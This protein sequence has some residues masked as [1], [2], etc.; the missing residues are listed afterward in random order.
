[1]TARKKPPQPYAGFEQGPIR[2]P[3]ESGSLLI[4]VTR[5]C[6]WNHCAFCPVY[7]GTRFS[8]RPAEHVRRDIDTVH[9]HV[10]SIREAAASDGRLDRDRVRRL[11]SDAPPGE[12]AAFQAAL[13]WFAGGLKS[14]F[15]QDANS[16]VIPPE[17]MIGI[18]R[19]LR[20]RFPW[21]E[22]IT[23][24]ARSHT[25]ARISG[26]NLR[27]MREAGLN[28]IHIGMESGSDRVLARVRKGADKAT[29]V[30]AGRKIKAAGMSLSEYVMPGLGGR[31]LSE[32]HARETADALNRI[33]PDF[34]RLRTLAL[35][36][37]VPLAK[38]HRSGEFE[39]LGGRETVAE[40]RL[41]VASLS[42]IASRVVS[43]HILNL[44]QEVEGRLPEDRERMLAVLDGFLDMDPEDQC[45]YQ[46][47][48]RIGVF[49]RLSDMESPGR[50]RRVRRA[51]DEHR[52]TPE[53]VDHVV[54][55]LMK[56]F[57]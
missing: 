34:I 18:L 37:G 8:L 50:M 9:R 55:E 22:R 54:E 43:D 38:A 11:S 29:Q 5:N 25:V 12:T 49:S 39:K 32:E 30:R 48:R 56:R 14:I 41:F 20:D 13:H 52:I 4:R 15:L 45:A 10:E 47:G 42:G 7:K 46:V 6:P 51:M 28:R 17:E 53:N 57:I 31:D 2:P 21:A 33:D 26:E 3:S 36:G 19:H 35:P 16:L 27:K 1:M 40:I 44:F 24:Y 23:S